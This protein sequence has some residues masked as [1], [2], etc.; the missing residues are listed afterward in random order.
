MPAYLGSTLRGAFGHAFRT[1]CC[2]ARPGEPCPVPDACAY[3]LIFESAPR[4]G[5]DA[6]SGHDEIPRP[7]VIAPPPAAARDY[8]AGADVPFDLTL[9]GR[10]REFLPH[11][12]VTLREVDRI[13]RGRRT[14]VL[15]R[16]DAVDPITGETACV[17]AGGEN[18]V[19]PED[20]AITLADC[21]AVP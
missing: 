11:F 4:R 3:H 17:Y 14:V 21:A 10:A 20:L 16:L 7:F 12:V 13:G 15:R 1:L 2:P 5:A 18:L 19:R 9:I 6:L 8:P